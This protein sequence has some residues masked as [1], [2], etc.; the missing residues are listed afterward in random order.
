LA[1]QDMMSTLDRRDLA[2]NIKRLRKFQGRQRSSSWWIFQNS[3]NCWICVYVGPVGNGES[4]QG[5]LDK[6]S[7]NPWIDRPYN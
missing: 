6:L 5:S 4:S 2:K 1:I 3:M 7:G